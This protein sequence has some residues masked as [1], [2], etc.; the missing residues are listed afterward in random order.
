MIEDVVAAPSTGY[1]WD[2]PWIK[3][4][5]SLKSRLGDLKNAIISFILWAIVN[6]TMP[7]HDSEWE[8]RYNSDPIFRELLHKHKVIRI[9]KGW[10]LTKELRNPVHNAYF[11]AAMSELDTALRGYVY[12]IPEKKHDS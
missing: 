12:A 7:T 2:R 6:P 11:Q 4:Q 3:T 9:D 8:E 10:F 1:D 5:I